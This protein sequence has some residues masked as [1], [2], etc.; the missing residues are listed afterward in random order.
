MDAVAAAGLDI[1]GLDAAYD[2]E[3]PFPH[4]AED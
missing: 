4:P 2:P 3:I 1:P